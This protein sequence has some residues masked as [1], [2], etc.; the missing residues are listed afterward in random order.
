VFTESI[1]GES[2][3]NRDPDENSIS[4]LAL[5]LGQDRVAVSTCDG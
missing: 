2:Y 3:N 1:A 5:K 4:S